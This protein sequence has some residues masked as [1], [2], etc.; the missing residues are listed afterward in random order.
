MEKLP[1]PFEKYGPIV[2]DALAEIF[3]DKDKNILE[4]SMAYS[5]LSKGKRIRPVLA[6]TSYELCGGADLKEISKCA[7]GIELIHAYSLIHDDLP[8]MDNDDFRRGVLTNHKVFGE[9][10]AILAG[11]AL[12]TLGLELLATYPEGSSFVR[13]RIKS[14]KQILTA[15]GRKGMALGQAIDISKK[16][17]E[18]DEKSLL[19]MHNLKTGKLL[20]ASILCG[21]IWANADSKTL[22]ALKAFAKP[23]GISFQLSD[24]ILDEVSTIEKLGK[25]PGKDKRDNKKTLV[26]LWGLEK[27]KANLE[28]YLSLA[29]RSLALFGDKAQDLR[30][31]A[32]FIAKRDF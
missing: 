27:A 6:M 2:E 26:S 5:V 22:K 20:E 17:D 16:D 18:F 23:L 14:L 4:K 25:T 8:S 29:L 12:Q 32:R 11:D 31:I 10:I 21:A 28:N 1:R 19:E 7:C 3:E 24:D 30:D 9:A 15:I 13:K